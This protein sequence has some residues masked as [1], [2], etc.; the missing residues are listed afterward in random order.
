[1]RKRVRKRTEY[2]L[3]SCKRQWAHKTSK[4]EERMKKAGK[5]EERSGEPVSPT[6]R[7]AQTEGWGKEYTTIEW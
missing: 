2:H 6:A 4:A 7:G 5:G 3:P 1:M